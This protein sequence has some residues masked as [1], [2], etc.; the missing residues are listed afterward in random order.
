MENI[1]SEFWKDVLNYDGLYQISNL[2]NVK[3]FHRI[4]TRIL[5]TS[6]D[7]N[8]YKVVVLSLRGVNKTKTIHRLVAI[9][10]LDNPEN[11]PQVNH[12]NGIKTDN[13]IENLEWNTASENLLH[14]H[15]IGLKKGVFGEKN[16]RS[17]LKEHQIIEIRK[18][19]KDGISQSEIAKKYNISKTSIYKIASNE[20][21]VTNESVKIIHPKGFNVMGSKNPNSKINKEMIKDMKELRN[22][23][24]LKYREIAS[25][26]GLSVSTINKAVNNKTYL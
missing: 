15:K 4:K 3:S 17:K 26:Y 21:W 20:N 23:K 19:I 24:G 2:G 7:T 16:K 18:N 1:E 11:K 14:A 22:I 8:G 12:I 10:F 13:H 25:I 6:C 5:K 9:H